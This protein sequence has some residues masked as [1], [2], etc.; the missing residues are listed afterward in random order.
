M[1]EGMDGCADPMLLA[2]LSE[3]RGRLAELPGNPFWE[4]T[5]RA[6]YDWLPGSPAQRAAW[7]LGDISAAPG[8]P[9]AAY[10]GT[11]KYRRMQ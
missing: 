2:I 8:L 7:L 4:A 6:D 9:P 5:V 11:D 1:S 3:M 10:L